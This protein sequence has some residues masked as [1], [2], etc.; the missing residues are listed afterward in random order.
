M[1]ET[2]KVKLKLLIYFTY[3]IYYYK[4]FLHCVLKLHKN[5]T[6]VTQKSNH[7]M[8]PIPHATLLWLA[9]SP[10]QTRVTVLLRLD[11]ERVDHRQNRNFAF[12]FIF[13]DTLEGKF[14]AISVVR[15]A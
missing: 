1:K 3:Y 13:C 9:E 8:Q 6:K 11:T 14:E 15:Y 10:S 4:H 7:L 2:N 5:N 12:F